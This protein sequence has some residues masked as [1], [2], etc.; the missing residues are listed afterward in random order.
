MFVLYGECVLNLCVDVVC[1]MLRCV[2][3]LYVYSVRPIEMYVRLPIVCPSVCLPV[4]LSVYLSIVCL[5]GCRLVC[6][7]VC[8]PLPLNMYVYRL[9]VFL[10]VCMSV[11]LSVI[12]VWLSSVC[13]WQTQ[14]F[15][16]AATF[17]NKYYIQH[18]GRLLVSLIDKSV[19]NILWYVVC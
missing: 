19:S 15:H 5:T 12:F 2:D 3:V 4:C 16:E 10:H 14:W 9:S 7:H 13:L 17:G 6:L 18:T 11:G 8:Q 1:C